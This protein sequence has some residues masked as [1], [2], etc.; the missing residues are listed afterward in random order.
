MNFVGRRAED[1]CPKDE[2]EKWNATG[3]EKEPAFASE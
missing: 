2:E 1:Q 3:V